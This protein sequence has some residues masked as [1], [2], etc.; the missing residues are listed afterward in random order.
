MGCY[1]YQN[2]PTVP[3]EAFDL[4]VGHIPETQHQ[5]VI[6][7]KDRSLVDCNNEKLLELHPVLKSGGSWND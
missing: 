1:R 3:T 4:V 5:R 2:R 7:T 6:S